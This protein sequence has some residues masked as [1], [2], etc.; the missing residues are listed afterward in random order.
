[1]SSLT[2]GMS[3]IVYPSDSNAEQTSLATSPSSFGLTFANRVLMVSYI[4]PTE[5]F[6]SNRACRKERP[7]RTPAL[8]HRLILS[9]RLKPL[10]FRTA[11][12]IFHRGNTVHRGTIGSL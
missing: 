3:A 10:S 11:Y 12:S 1:M 8:L 2:L 5:S 9:P 6:T 7:N 4:L